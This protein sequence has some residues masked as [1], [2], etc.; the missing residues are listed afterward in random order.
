MI[1]YIMKRLTLFLLSFITLTL[2]WPAVA[3]ATLVTEMGNNTHVLKISEFSFP[4]ELSPLIRTVG[5]N[6]IQVTSTAFSQFCNISPTNFLTQDVLI[7]YNRC[8]LSTKALVL[9]NVTENGRFVYVNPSQLGPDDW[10]FSYNG[11]TGIDTV[12]VSGQKYLIAIKHNEQQNLSAG[13]NLYQNRVFPNIRAEDCAAGYFNGVFRQC[14]QSFTSY[15]SI[16]Y[17]PI[18][19]AGV[20]DG[21]QFSDIGPI[22]WPPQGYKDVN[23]TKKSSGFYHP[24]MYV[25][26][27]HVYAYYLNDNN[28]AQGQRKCIS[29]SR[30]PI[31]QFNDPMAWKNYYQGAF[32]TQSLPNGFNKSNMSNFYT[33]GGGNADCI[34]LPS[35]TSDTIIYFNVAKIDGTDLYIGTEESS[36]NHETWQVGVRVSRDLINWSNMQVLSTASVPWGQGNLSYPTFIDSGGR[37]TNELIQPNSFYLVGKRATN[38]SGYELNSKHLRL[39]MQ[40]VYQWDLDQLFAKYGDNMFNDPNKDGIV[41]G[42]DLVKV[43]NSRPAA[44]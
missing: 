10:R 9:S 25:G 30:A 40:D 3:E 15:V 29:I 43:I 34:G 8:H 39:N 2:L 21:S 20:V 31:A 36:P 19:S 16:G 44:N 41:N 22:V 1:V 6:Q 28:L 4:P 5:N 37:N 18:D 17:A 11:V 32:G 33:V 38:S 7:P 24:T 35:P 14:W 27:S 42:M 13:G 26:D 12:E 23:N